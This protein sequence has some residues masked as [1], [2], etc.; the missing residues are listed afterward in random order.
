MRT[1]SMHC[2]EETLPP[3]PGAALLSFGVFRYHAGKDADG[4]QNAESPLLPIP[5]LYFLQS[6]L[7][8]PQWFTAD[9]KA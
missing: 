2:V 9:V 6:L 8:V 7:S 5:V 1:L 4:N 3:G